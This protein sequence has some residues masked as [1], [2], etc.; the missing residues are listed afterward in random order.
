M[1]IHG[2]LG[3]VKF[4]TTEP[5]GIKDACIVLAPAPLP[6]SFA[7]EQVGRIG[8]EAAGR[9]VLAADID[10]VVDPKLFLLAEQRKIELNRVGRVLELYEQRAIIRRQLRGQTGARC[11]DARGK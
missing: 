4:P 11:F 10:K 3:S 7:D 8:G 5:L 2:K 6:E 1:S 9:D